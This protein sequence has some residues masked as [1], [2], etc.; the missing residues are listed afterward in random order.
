MPKKVKQSI[1]DFYKEKSD[2][3]IERYGEKSVVL[4]MVG[5]FFEI[6]G[7]KNTITGDIFG[8]PI[9]HVSDVTG[10]S[11]ADKSGNT[12]EENVTCVMAG[13]PDYRIDHFL[14]KLNKAGY[15]V[16]VYTQKKGEKGSIIRTQDYITSPG[17]FFHDNDLVV[18]NN[19][20]CV[21]LENTPPSR[22]YTKSRIVIGVS[23]I[24]ILTG[25]SNYNQFI[26]DYDH[27][28]NNFDELER[29]LTVY[30]PKEIIFIYNDTNLSSSKLDDIV[31][32][33][34]GY[35]CV[36]RRINL[37]DTSNELSLMAVNCEKQT[38]QYTT[39][40]TFFKPIDIY[41]F[42]EEHN[43]NYECCS[44]SSFS[45]LL[46]YAQ[47]HNSSLVKRLPFPTKE[48]K[49]SYMVVG[50]H[51]LKQL[52]II[53]TH[54]SNGKY[55]SV[56]K[57]MN[58]CYT[59]MGKREFSYQL[60]HPSLDTEWITQ[61]Y[62]M[63]DIFQKFISEHDD[64]SLK[65][66]MRSCLVNS[67]DLSRYFRRIVMNKLRFCDIA[68]LYD[69]IGYVRKLLHIVCVD[70]NIMNYMGT[71]LHNEVPFELLTNHLKYLDDI[72]ETYIDVEKCKSYSI[73]NIHSCNFIKKGNF[74]YLDNAEEKYV[75]TIDILNNITSTFN[76]IYDTN[77][78][79]KRNSVPCRI[80]KT[81]KSG[82]YIDSTKT[83]TKTILDNVDKNLKVL[84]KSSY[85]GKF[86][87]FCLTDTI[88]TTKSK[89]SR[90]RFTSRQIDAVSMKNL[91]YKNELEC[92]LKSAFNIITDLFKS[93][94]Q[95]FSDLSTFM[96][97]IDVLF[98]KARLSTELN[99][100]RPTINTTR[101]EESYID[102]KG[103]RHTLIEHIQTQEIY[104]PNDITIGVN[105]EDD[106]EDYRSML[107]FGTNAVGKSSFIKSV[108]IALILAQSGMYVPCSSF[109]YSPFESIYT[110]IIGND[111]IFKGL[112]TFAVE[113]I[114]LQNILR[115]SNEKTLVLG[116]EL[117]SGTEHGSAI[118]I[119]V[120]GVQ[121]L[122]MK[123]TKSIFATHFHEVTNMEELTG[124]KDIVF[125]H[126]SVEYDAVMDA[127]IY[128]RIIKDG[129][130]SNSYGLE[131]CKS[132]NLP[133]DFLDM[134]QNIRIRVHEEDKTVAHHKVSHFNS[135]KIMGNCEM[136][137]KKGADV[138]HMQ[139]Q[140][141]ADERGFIKTFHK[142]HT[143]N[144]MNLCKNC[145]DK[146]HLKN[147]KLVKRKTTRGKKIVEL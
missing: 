123:G 33:V 38:Y 45:F 111:N 74:E 103:L 60:L 3:L 25:D 8:S 128:N 53:D 14:S 13:F 77:K 113:M 70:T 7:F 69:T 31:N 119:F 4:M 49:Q 37:N 137:G 89:Q 56:L 83:H 11:I 67:C 95:V 87:E 96:K 99:Y 92:Q 109:E 106:C 90:L 82:Y 121:Y 117:C 147:T 9:V 104:V 86:S 30:N 63:I 93:N 47:S 54:D 79:T 73:E 72:Y 21:W 2:Y 66:Q 126:M 142:N 124:M 144:L 35:N 88:T 80:Q 145:H 140:S 107:L 55:S 127:L 141:D 22:L 120:A 112:S 139:Y 105:D 24:D 17:T 39:F 51:S 16:A 59:N 58:K 68:T 129:P 1:Y 32:F 18:S 5:S 15:T 42:M 94:E 81:E 46:N 12:G 125:K 41:T 6:Y 131:V 116:D 27:K 84:Y 132:L 134:A 85:N 135:K 76:T 146:I 57:L 65:T 118:S 34:S 78:T 143:A 75:T 97:H 36:N 115:Y 64:T 138:H 98:L 114:E 23:T 26:N 91:Q 44:S 108:G 19:I 20:T 102:A 133:V 48:Y 28:P 62:Y 43:F 110:R 50:N 100:C 136:C 130:G 71:L 61:Q 10:L 122:T 52:N 40:D 29:Y 101:Q